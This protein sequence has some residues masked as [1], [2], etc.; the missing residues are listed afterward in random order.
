MQ[1]PWD[2]SLVNVVN[3]FVNASFLQSKLEHRWLNEKL[4]TIFSVGHL[5]NFTL[6]TS[7]LFLSLSLSLSL[8]LF[9]KLYQPLAILSTPFSI[10]VCLA[11]RSWIS[12]TDILKQWSIRKSFS[13][14]DYRKIDA[15]Q[16]QA[17][18]RLLYPFPACCAVTQ[19]KAQAT[20][21]AQG[22]PQRGRVLTPV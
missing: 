18:E 21:Q 11:H 8:S 3:H 14:I 22:Y 16:S 7:S 20:C 15:I 13:Q 5:L 10:S 17:W 6:P 2:Q 9:K 19:A 1:A 4:L 12:L